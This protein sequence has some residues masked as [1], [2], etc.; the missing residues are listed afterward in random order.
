MVNEAAQLFGV[1][2]CARDGCLSPWA[3]WCG[4]E[5]LVYCGAHIGAHDCKGIKQPPKTKKKA[6]R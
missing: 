1:A 6:R 4:V 3:R 2:K 5:N